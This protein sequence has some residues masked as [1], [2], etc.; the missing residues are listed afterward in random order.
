MTHN[1]K[2]AAMIKV[3]QLTLYS[4]QH[5]RI[6]K[7]TSELFDTYR[8]WEFIDDAFEG[9]H[10]QGPFATLE[11]LRRISSIQAAHCDSK[12]NEEAIP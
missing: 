6:L 2:I 12:R 1:E 3:E 9:L 11:E 8:V 7:E 5:S 4:K 10:V